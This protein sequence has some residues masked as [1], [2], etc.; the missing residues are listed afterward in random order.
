[1]ENLILPKPLNIN[2]ASQNMR[3]INIST[4]N[5]ITY[6]KLIAVTKCKAEVIF[7][8][9]VRLNSVKQKSSLHDLEKK[10]QGLGY[11]IFHNSKKSSRGVAILI[12]SKIDLIVHNTLVDE[13]TD[14]YMVMDITLRKSRLII[15]SVYGPNGNDEVD[16]YDRLGQAIRQL[17]NNSVVLGGDW[18]ATWDLTRVDKNLDT[19]NMA[20]IPSVERST[21]IHQL[22]DNFRLTD[23]FRVFYPTRKE[24]TYVPAAI[25]QLNRSRI[26]FFLVSKNL[27]PHCCNCRISN[28]LLS[29]DFDHKQITLIFKN[30]NMGGFSIVKD[31]PLEGN[32]TENY[33]KANLMESYIQHATINDV[34]N[35]QTRDDHL[36]RIATVLRLLEQI[37]SIELESAKTEMNNLNEMTIAANR[38]E[39]N[40]IF[41]DLPGLDFFENLT[42]TC[43]S[44][45]FFE[46]SVMAIKN[47]AMLHQSH[48]YNL[49]KAKVN[50]LTL[51]INNWKK[52]YNLN[53]NRILAGER[54]LAT[55]IEN[56]LKVEL[57]H[58][59]VFDKLNN[60]KITP[61]FMALAK[62]SG[63]DECLTDVKNDNN[64]DFV[65]KECQ[66]KY[67][68][69]FYKNLYTKRDLNEELM[70]SIE[71]FLGDCVNNET[72]INSKLTENE[73]N[74]LDSELTIEEFDKSV[75]QANLN[76]APGINGI[77]NRFIKKFWQ[78]FRVPL[79]KY[80]TCA[81]G[82]GALTDSFSTAK[83]KL[84]PK[85]GDCTRIKN[86]RPISLLNCF[87]KILSRLITTRIR[88]YIDKLTP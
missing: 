1:V 81:L 62:K 14:N 50:R 18:N 42:L 39:I 40:L 61:H 74:D 32:D 79:F 31:F 38:G 35:I 71:D 64:E 47:G 5:D 10:V 53:V 20:N 22:A 26:D 3:S 36:A 88:K 37:R 72:V 57:E 80:S 21:A 49:K 2:F 12:N 24:Y 15:G 87:Y 51:E 7:L 41:N 33:I 9:D 4:K 17:G 66:E 54:E 52:S 73:K 45:T 13:I 29:T 19:L 75:N 30:E 82:R 60:E 23:P 28:T 68:F 25:N 77:S 78:F 69:N 58:M 85:K 11:K 27:L 76:S 16:L 46:V 70:V 43:D 48:Y 67:I 65:R 34:Y 56:E 55:I 84:I 59:R 83:I 63:S 8:C 44:C 86:W 6:K